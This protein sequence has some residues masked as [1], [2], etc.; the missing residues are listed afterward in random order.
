M[1]EFAINSTRSTINESTGFVPF[2][3][4]Y[5]D[6]SYIYRREMMEP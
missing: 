1:V 4:I 2:E 3:P 6:C 5:D